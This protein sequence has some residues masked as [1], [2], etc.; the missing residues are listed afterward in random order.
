MA[1]EV[2][3]DGRGGRRFSRKR[4]ISS[5]RMS[6][7]STRGPGLALGLLVL[8]WACGEGSKPPAGSHENAGSG[9][10]V[11]AGTGG[12]LGGAAGRESGSGGSDA[13]S[14]GTGSSGGGVESSGGSGGRGGNV[15]GN[16]GAMLDGAGES[17][18]G[19]RLDNT[20]AGKSS[21]KSG[22]IESTAGQAGRGAGGVDDGKAG[23]AGSTGS[24]LM[25]SKL[26]VEPNPNM[27]ISCF[28]SWSTEEPASSEVDFGV[29]TYAFRIRDATPVTEH[30]VLVIG[31]HAETDYKLKAISST[32]AKH[33]ETEG[34]FT[35]GPL[36][37]NF[38]LTVLTV[39]NPAKVQS[40]WTLTAVNVPT[41]PT[42]VVM[43]DV[44]GE[45]VWYY[46]DT[47]TADD[48]FANYLGGSILINAGTN[49]P[50]REVD[51]AGRVLWEGPPNSDSLKRETHDIRKTSLGTYLINTDYWIKT[52]T[53]TWIDAF[54][55]ELDPDL[56][57]LWS[58]HLFDHQPPTGTRGDV[59]HG[60]AMTLDE[61]ND[62]LYY[63]CRFLGLLKVDR[64]T[65]D[66]L[67]RMGGTYDTKTYGPGDFTFEPPESQ[68][69]DTH[70][71]ELHDDG[72]ILFYDNGGYDVIPPGGR[73]SRVVEYQVDEV[74][75]TAVR[76]FE[77]PGDFDVDDW[78]KKSW[79][80]LIMG[81]ANRLANGNI[82]VDAPTASGTETNHIF[83]ITRA[84]E[85]VW[86]IT[87]PAGSSAYRTRR[88]SPPPLVE[89]LP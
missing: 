58:W 55:Q 53:A 60:N 33:G 2:E 6:G 48:V 67:W 20:G 45:P 68:Y 5:R 17:G 57:E 12:M 47:P 42:Y 1:F 34:T 15:R 51:L 65:G 61:S 86:Q 36:P 38:P 11:D 39:E 73:H 22:S 41:A 10:H 83:E 19:G 89:R 28:V 76:T 37:A 85:V 46:V 77:F 25:I 4:L 29:D 69:D 88:L 7:I 62:V 27:T 32:E 26:A 74:A 75:K 14:T 24:E 23:A 71:P 43:Y 56:N 35:T 49:G 9:A 54:V 40:G 84:G 16:G 21:G 52:S 81:S 30:R 66:I 8:A 44:N 79:Y 13:G 80:S 64:A 78:Y 18:E 59:C 70:D 31:M 82:L 87:L 3:P 50:A 63:N 72:T